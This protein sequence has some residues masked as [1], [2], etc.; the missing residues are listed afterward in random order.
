MCGEGFETA[1]LRL[2]ERDKIYTK[3]CVIQQCHEKLNVDGW[4][5]RAGGCHH[6]GSKQRSLTLPVCV[7]LH[8]HLRG[9]SE[10]DE[11]CRSQTPAVPVPEGPSSRGLG[12][13]R[14]AARLSLP[15]TRGHQGPQTPGCLPRV[16]AEEPLSQQEETPP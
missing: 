2:L 12:D 4:F 14:H 16:L 10:K 3:Y 7:S 11:F 6:I 8:S 9:S 15:T 1:S 5:S 13:G